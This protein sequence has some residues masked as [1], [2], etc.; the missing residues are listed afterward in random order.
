MKHHLMNALGDLR[1]HLRKSGFT[2]LRMELS[3]DG[4]LVEF[5]FRVQANSKLKIYENAYSAVLGILLEAGFRVG[6]EELA[7][8]VNGENLDG[9]FLVRPL[10]EICEC[11]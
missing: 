1:R 4:E 8:N 6:F 10:A 2:K 7:L 5:S 9:A 11:R 3:R